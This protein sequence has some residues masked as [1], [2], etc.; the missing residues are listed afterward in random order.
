MIRGQ[1]LSQS[2][3][4]IGLIFDGSG[5]LYVLDRSTPA[6]VIR[7]D[8]TTGKQ[9]TFATFSDVPLCGPRRATD[10]SYTPTDLRPGPDVGAF[11]P[12]GSLYVT[13]LEQ[14]L[15]WRV[16][17]GGGRARVWFTD[18]R[19]GSG[20]GPNGLQ[21][22]ADGKSLLFVV[23]RGTS[24]NNAQ[25]LVLELPITRTGRPGR[26]HDFWS[27][28][29]GYDGLVISRAG[30]VYVAQALL[31]YVLK[32]SPSGHEMAR[33]QPPIRSTTPRQSL[34]TGP[35]VSPSWASTCS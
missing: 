4:V 6:R 23:T 21:V 17:Q 34:S 11:G 13:D 7:L 12:D 10:C 31:N 24:R 16:P 18:R 5:L 35:R 14:G 15:I 19:L 25:G 27:G 26:L 3:G 8:P 2:H 22:R 28:P 33:I 30:N 1:H 29:L 32:L 20:S 9:Q